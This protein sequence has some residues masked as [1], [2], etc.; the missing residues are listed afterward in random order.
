MSIFSGAEFIVP[1]QGNGLAHIGFQN[2]DLL[3]CGSDLEGAA[4]IVAEWD[5]AARIC[6]MIGG[7]L[8][9]E[10]GK[11]WAPESCKQ[12]GQVLALQRRIGRRTAAEVP[13]ECERKGAL[14]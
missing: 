1:V 11:V 13:E 14:T 7:R 3:Y 10:A 2:G 12:F 8:F 6:T 5:G 4:C 9:D